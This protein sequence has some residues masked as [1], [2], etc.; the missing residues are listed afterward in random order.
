M[1]S[2]V[3]TLGLLTVV[4]SIQCAPFVV[5]GVGTLK[6]I[7]LLTGQKREFEGWTRN[8]LL[9]FLSIIFLPGT[10]VY[11]AI[12][13]VL[14]KILGI[15]V[16]DIAGSAA[17]GELNIFLRIDKPPRVAV[18][19]VFLYS[20]IILSIFVAIS[21][22]VFPATLLVSNPPI[23]LVCWYVALGVFFNTSVRSGD[24][25]VLLAS[26]KKRPRSGAIELV[27]VLVMIVILHTQLVGV[28]S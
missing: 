3:L 14:C 12:R 26:L 1:Q 7:L 16:A 11:I 22:I 25:S 5:I 10:L 24:L 23:V 13:Y 2:D 6:G 20:T 18:L 27:T 21:M 28:I 8:S 15:D 19:L 4:F 9:S 17:Y